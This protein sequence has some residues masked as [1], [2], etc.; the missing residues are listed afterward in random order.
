MGME[1]SLSVHFS[2]GNGW[3]TGTLLASKRSI[4]TIQYAN[5]FNVPMYLETRND[6]V[7]S[8]FQ[9]YLYLMSSNGVC[10]SKEK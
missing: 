4:P 6:T 2:F 10:S 7:Q 9:W 8:F 3:V 5:H 1:V